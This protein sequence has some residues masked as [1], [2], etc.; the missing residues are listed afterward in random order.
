MGNEYQRPRFLPLL[1]KTLGGEVDSRGFRA[2]VPIWI[3][4]CLA[5]GIG[6]AFVLPD[7]FWLNN[8]LSTS[9]TLYSVI[10]TI[11][12]LILALSWNAF[13]RI[14]DSIVSSPG[15]SLFL[16]EETLLDGYL[17]YVD[18]VHAAQLIALFSSFVSVVV[19]LIDISSIMYDRIVFGASIGL[20]IYAIKKAVDVVI[21]M[22]DLIWHKAIFEEGNDNK[23]D[24]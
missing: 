11:N 10:I 14:H 12:G 13:S 5:I 24:T 7:R 22:H 16:R 2:V 6:V 15:F 17:L 23:N 20:S 19:L 18:Y 1:F 21:V 8:N 9:L 3:V 4:V